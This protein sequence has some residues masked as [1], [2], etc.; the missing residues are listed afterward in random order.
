MT[1]EI[2]VILLWPHLLKLLKIGVDCDTVW[3]TGDDEKGQIEEHLI[4]QKEGL[5]IRGFTFRKSKN[6]GKIST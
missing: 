6:W 5:F 3:L 4:R 2:Q 1:W